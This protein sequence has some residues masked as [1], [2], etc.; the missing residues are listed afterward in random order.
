MKSSAG[1][2]FF[3]MT[4]SGNDFVI[5]D[6]RS[7]PAGELERPERIQ[8]LSARGTGVGSDGVVFI[9]PSSRADYYMRYYNSDGSR[10]S[11]CGNASLCSA[12]LAVELGLV[13]PAGFSFESDA[14][15]YRA[16]IRDGEPEIDVDAIEIVQPELPLG[17]VDGER[18]LGY[19]VAGNPHYVVFCDSVAGVDVEG[20]GREL[21]MDPSQ[22]EGANV[23]FVSREPEGWAI[24][25]YERGVEGETLACGT[26][27]VA[28][29]ILLTT[30]GEARS[31]AIFRTKS[32]RR[33]TVS[34]R[35]DGTRWLASLRGEGRLVYRGELQDV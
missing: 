33:L 24:R 9:D 20:R 27:S 3:K 21:R 6:A 14:G 1:R 7:E 17:R 35:K 32:G 4:G 29:A 11:M 22:P 12:R 23:N 2:P 13:D 16:R 30:W 25:T 19:A 15:V 34:L 8:A 5:F 10:A 28:S 31:G 18:K 26:G